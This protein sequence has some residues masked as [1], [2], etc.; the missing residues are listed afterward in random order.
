MSD[1]PD[2][3]RLQLGR[4]LAGLRDRAGATR[5]QAAEALDCTPGKISKVE[6]GKLGLSR[7]EVRTLLRLYGVPGEGDEATRLLTIAD[8][9]RRRSVHRVPE[10]VR[11]YIGL[12]ANASEIQTFEIEPVPGLLQTEAYTRA[13]AQATTAPREADRLVAIRRNRQARL[14]GDNPPSFGV[15][16]HEAALRVLVGGPDVMREQLYRLLEVAELP[17]VSLRVLPFAAGAH[18]SMGGGFSIVGLP[19]GDRVVYLE[20][21]WRADYVRL[22]AHVAAYVQVFDTLGSAALDGSGTETLIR[23]VIEDLE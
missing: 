7:L 23:E 18:P 6:H 16:M 21:L 22:P 14:F 9:A 20:T 17:H 10:W 2:A 4:E 8:E 3:R 19:E 13:T 12:E 11:E 15:V 1:T 5:Q